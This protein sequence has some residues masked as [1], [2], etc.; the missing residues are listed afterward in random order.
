MLSLKNVTI[1]Y[2]T[3]EAVRGISLIVEPGALT[4]VI[5]ANGAGKST[6]LKGISGLIP[7]EFG[8]IW[9]NDRRIDGL[10]AHEVVR[11]G[12]SHVPEGRRPFPHMNVL[13]NLK[14]GSYL[15]RDRIS[16]TKDLDEIFQRFPVL[17]KR[18]HQKAGTLS[19]GEQQMLA[20]GRSL[21]ARPSLLLMDEPSVGL[22]PIVIKEL[23]TV[24]SDIVKRGIDVLLVEQ[25]AGLV[26]RVSD[27]G[28]V[29]ELGSVV[30]SG[31][32]KDLTGNELVR[33]AFL[34]K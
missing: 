10:P 11:M 4:S 31:D 12:I 8:E 18:R 19:G 23:A 16:I 15:R 3:Y 9:F 29:L 27:R 30:L 22:A 6:I 25:N 33:K 7:L 20:I 21:M 13:A 34:G 14:I 26:T 2:G 28:Y 24:I 17:R 1:H 5:G 32:M